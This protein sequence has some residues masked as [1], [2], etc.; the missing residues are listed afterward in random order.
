MRCLRR[1][2]AIVFVL[3]TV[4]VLPGNAVAWNAKGHWITAYVAYKNLTPVARSRVD[5]L[6]RIHPDYARWRVRALPG[7]P[8]GS[9]ILS[10]ATNLAIFIQASTWA[11]EIKGDI[12]FYN[13]GDKPTPLLPGY[14]SMERRSDWHF[15]QVPISVDGVAIPAMTGVSLLDTLQKMVAELSTGSDMARAYN[16]PWLIHIVG[17]LHQPLHCVTR[18]S[19]AHG[20]PL[21]DLGGNAFKVRDGSQTTNLHLYWDNLPP[22]SFTE[23]NVST[24]MNTYNPGKD[25]SLNPRTWVDEGITLAKDF[26]YTVGPDR[27]GQ[28]PP[29]MKSSY[30]SKAKDK[31]KERLVVAGFRLAKIL[32]EIFQ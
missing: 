30:K 10:S 19:L 6:L 23:K 28:P 15:I 25:L 13:D 14:V 27:P 24:W 1:K 29:A 5:K 22:D 2:V 9:I 16:L 17:D 8:S 11:D 31:A 21:G 26:V 32:N 20:A 18:F 12:R 7:T 4:L 3:L